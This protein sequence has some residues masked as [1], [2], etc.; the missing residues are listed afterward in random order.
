[1]QGEGVVACLHLRCYN[2]SCL[3]CWYVQ[4]ILRGRSCPYT[5]DF[6]WNFA[7]PLL[8]LL[9]EM[10]TIVRVPGASVAGSPGDHTEIDSVVHLGCRSTGNASIE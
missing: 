1:M 7:K 2:H 6:T 5:F 9:L 8:Q 4:L 10:M 3:S